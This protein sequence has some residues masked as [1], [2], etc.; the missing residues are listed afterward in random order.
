MDDPDIIYSTSGLI[1]SLSIIRMS[2]GTIDNGRGMVTLRLNHSLYFV[3]NYPRENG[4]KLLS[5]LVVG[6]LD[7]FRSPLNTTTTNMLTVTNPDPVTAITI[8]S[9]GTS[10][11]NGPMRRVTNST[12]PYVFPTGKGSINPATFVFDP[13]VVVPTSNEVSLYEAEYFETGHSDLVNVALPLTGVSPVEYWNISK[14]SG[15]DASVQLTVNARVPLVTNKYALVAAQ[16]VDG[17]WISQQGSVLIPGDTARGSVITKALSNLSQFTFG[18]YPITDISPLFLTCPS[19]TTV[20]ANL[21]SCYALIAFK[22]KS[23]DDATVVYKI[24]SRV[25]TFPYYFNKGTTTIDVTASDITGIKTCSFSVTLNDPL[26]FR[27]RFG[28][29]RSLRFAGVSSGTIDNGRNVVTLKINHSFILQNPVIVENGVTLLQPLQVGRLDLFRGALNTSSNRFITVNDPD[30]ATAVKGSGYVNGPI[31]RTNS[32]HA[33]VFPTGRGNSPPIPT[34]SEPFELI[35]ASAEP[36]VYQAEYF[37]PG[38][39]DTQ[40]VKPP[41][42][43]V[44]IAEYWDIKK[45]SG[46]DARVKL[47]VRGRVPRTTNNNVLVVARYADGQW[48]S[49]QGTVLSPGDTTAGSVVSKTLSEFGPFTFGYYPAAD[50]PPVFVN[51]PSNITV[52]ADQNGCNALVEFKAESGDNATIVYRIGTTVITSPYT[53][54]RGT[55]TVDVTASEVSGTAACSFTVTVNDVQAPVITGVSANPA[56]LSPADNELKNVFI[57]YR[58]T[59]NCGPV[60]TLLSVTIDGS[61][62]G[63]WE[64]IDEH[65]VRLRAEKSDEDRIYTITITS[66]DGSG[67][68]TIKQVTVTVPKTVKDKD[69]KIKLKV[70]VTPNPSRTYFTLHIT[71]NND[72]LITMQVFDQSGRIKEVRRFYPDATIK[73]GDDYRP[74]IYYVRFTQGRIEKNVTL[75]KLPN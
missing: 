41:L 22:A 72:K 31:R 39:I 65:N 60:T 27:D 18:Y 53:F 40:H 63:N 33:Y 71:S 16:Y 49:E 23:N 35:P 68:Q 8:G 42:T 36:S 37:Y 9:T 51:C 20:N 59:D 74:G 67:N 19:D 2:S 30:V 62:N 24:A 64:V 38:Y 73:L 10:Y 15:A 34:V 17:K 44:S 3:P 57:D 29:I 61:Q 32:T 50:I 69:K 26:A 5:S 25:I 11:V 66:M 14:I 47:T 4:F 56:I 58:V 46:S 28:L 52:N 75:I 55:S 43:G 13:C 6:R 7:L 54:Q 1:N 70:K 12:T 48:V 45:I 21:N